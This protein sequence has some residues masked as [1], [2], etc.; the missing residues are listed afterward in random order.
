M[1]GG[2]NQNVLYT[3]MKL[4]KQESNQERNSFK[5]GGA[6]VCAVS[7]SQWPWPSSIS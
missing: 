2:N 5:G 6:T 7:F 1:G 3:S 4:S